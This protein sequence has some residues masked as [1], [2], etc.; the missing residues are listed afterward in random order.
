[1]PKFWPNSKFFIQNGCGLRVDDLG[2]RQGAGARAEPVRE[3]LAL[4]ADPRM[5]IKTPNA[6]L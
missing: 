4:L 2:V 5:P 1:L 6:T 3:D